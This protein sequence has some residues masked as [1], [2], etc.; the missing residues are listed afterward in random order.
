MGSQSCKTGPQSQKQELPKKKSKD[1]Q[2][3]IPC[4]G[5][6]PCSTCKSTCTCTCACAC[7]SSTPSCSSTSSRP[8]ASPCPC[9]SP[10]SI[11]TCSP[12]SAKHDAADGS[13]SWWSCCRLCCR[14]GCWQR[15]LW[16]VLRRFLRPC[17]STCSGSCSC[18]SCPCSSAKRANWALRL[19]DQT[20]PAVQPDPVRH[21]QLRGL[22]R[23]AERMQ[24]EEPYDS[25]DSRSD[26][27]FG[28]T[29]RFLP[30]TSPERPHKLCGPIN[31]A[32]L[33][34]PCDSR[35]YSEASFVL[36]LYI[37]K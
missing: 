11:G 23:G 33:V 20:V 3:R 22:Q 19:G 34:C 14:P 16:D 30:K 9:S 6:C 36:S 32:F 25:L 24:A 21:H 13:H 31:R 2:E 1:A 10:C 27:D 7:C 8:P 18:T 28:T 17:T 15:H 37:R 26:Q 29:H 35:F 5:S 12:C 4:P